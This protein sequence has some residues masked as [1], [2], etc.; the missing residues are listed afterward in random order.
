MKIGN[1]W[2]KCNEKDGTTFLSVALD[3]TILAFCPQLKNVNISLSWVR[4]EDKKSEN[5]PDWTV[6]MTARKSEEEKAKIKAKK[7]EAEK[8]IIE[9]AAKTSEKPEPPLEE[10]YTLSKE[11]Q[12]EIPY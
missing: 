1:A 6:S 10:S 5:S 2:T 9:S 4:A 7:E 11:E 12:E 3:E 8:A